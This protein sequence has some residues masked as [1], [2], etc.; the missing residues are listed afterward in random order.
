MPIVSYFVKKVLTTLDVQC[1]EEHGDSTKHI[2]KAWS[3]QL[4]FKL[5]LV[6]LHVHYLILLTSN[7]IVQQSICLKMHSKVTYTQDSVKWKGACE[8]IL[9]RNVEDSESNI[10][11]FFLHE[12]KTTTPK[13]CQSAT[14]LT[15]NQTEK[16][17]CWRS[18]IN[19]VHELVPIMSA[20]V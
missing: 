2:Q 8:W 20:Y 19:I 12:E 4:L 14:F 15:K 1:T 18:Y 11:P 5:V 16:Q 9:E 10:V 13:N 6:K 7:I 17:E 3:T